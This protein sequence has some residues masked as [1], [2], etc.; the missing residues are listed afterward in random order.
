MV[1]IGDDVVIMSAPGRFKVIAIDA[2]VVTLE[3]AEGVRK[4]VLES[5]VRTLQK[6]LTP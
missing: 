4:R 2:A 5:S 1:Q 3:N 6:P